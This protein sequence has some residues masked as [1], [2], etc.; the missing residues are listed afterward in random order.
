MKKIIVY[1]LCLFTFCRCS[2]FSNE[3]ENLQFNQDNEVRELDSNDFKINKDCINESSCKNILTENLVFRIKHEEN[4]ELKNLYL[5]IK[6]ENNVLYKGMYKD[7]IKVDSI[8]FCCDYFVGNSYWFIFYNFNT[9]KYNT[10][11]SERSYPYCKENRI[12]LL[13]KENDNFE[14][15]EFDGCQW[16]DSKVTFGCGD[17][18]NGSFR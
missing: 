2:Y 1:I 17:G 8:K 13:Y 11:A 4:K 3:H 14:N 10:W 16:D 12:T 15:Y 9:K 6:S 7:V 18:V 5:I